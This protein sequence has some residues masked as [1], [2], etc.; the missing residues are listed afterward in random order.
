MT[1]D[2]RKRGALIAMAGA[3][4]AVDAAVLAL[5]RA[6]RGAARALPAGHDLFSEFERLMPASRVLQRK[7][8]QALG[9]VPVGAPCACGGHTCPRTR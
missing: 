2:V 3:L 7:A 1:D 9:R 8:E 5:E 6:H 4:E